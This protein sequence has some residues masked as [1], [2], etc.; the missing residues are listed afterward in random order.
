MRFAITVSCL[1]LAACGSTSRNNTASL[2]GAAVVPVGESS[3]LVFSAAGV[4]R[5]DGSTRGAVDAPVPRTAPL[6]VATDSSSGWAVVAYP[7]ALAV[8]NTSDARVKPIE[9]VSW[10]SP[11][12]ALGIGGTTI[13]TIEDGTIALY[14][15][16]EGKRL[17]KEDGRKLLRDLGLEELRY[18]MPLTRERM[19]VV[20][21]KA[22]G[23][24]SE[25][26]AMVVDIDRS[27]GMPVSQ[28]RPFGG[29]LHWLEACAGDG[30]SLFVA[31]TNQA[32]ENVGPRQQQMVKTILVLRHDPVRGRN[33]VLVRSRQQPSTE[34]HVT[35]LAAG[36]GLVAYTLDDGRVNV[37]DASGEREAAHLW[38]QPV[39]GL[40]AI[41]C[42]DRDH[43]AFV[44]GT[45]VEIQRVR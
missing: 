31:G 7:N 35:H 2:G 37:Y 36:F 34:V 3:V 22:M 25:P 39:P 33:Q 44:I 15:A 17:W 1:V 45:R 41:E 32:V 29:E 18:V 42:V 9:G 27:A 14:D 19:L 26:Q 16:L 11:P 6:A 4:E 10:E 13:G 43:V 30:Q 40:T 23:A 8:V 24:M 38:G 5:L 28:E 21:F 20:A 12:S